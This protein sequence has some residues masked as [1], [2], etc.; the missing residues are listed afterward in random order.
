M[1]NTKE[2]LSQIADGEL[3]S[4]QTDTLLSSLQDNTDIRE[5]WMA[6]HL[7]GDV[8]RDNS[9]SV[10][11]LD[12]AD[13]LRTLIENEPAILAPRKKRTTFLKPVA[14][15]AI[16]ASVAAIAVLGVRNLDQEMAPYQ[17]T[18]EQVAQTSNSATTVTAKTIVPVIPQAAPSYA[19]TVEFSSEPTQAGFEQQFPAATDRINSYMINYNEQQ[20]GFGM[21]PY[22]RVI[23]FDSTE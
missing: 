9:A 16:A 6:Y 10:V 14:G 3:S 21:M 2:Q 5:S 8:M 20:G 22:A 17:A 13:R 23:S 12:M 18:N 4:H 11:D 1:N 19:R 15:F 7:I